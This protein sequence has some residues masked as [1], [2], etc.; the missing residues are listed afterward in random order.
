MDYFED[1]SQ[2]AAFFGEQA[3]LLGGH[4]LRLSWQTAFE[5]VSGVYSPWTDRAVR[6]Y[7]SMREWPIL[8]DTDRFEL[9]L[10][11]QCAR[12]YCADMR[13]RD[14]LAEGLVGENF[15]ATVESLL[16]EYWQDVG[17]VDFLASLE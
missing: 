5:R 15:G 4:E 2:A 8:E 16:I 7:I 17:R 6:S 9:L 12:W 1:W 14:P 13:S 10:R 11:L 3:E